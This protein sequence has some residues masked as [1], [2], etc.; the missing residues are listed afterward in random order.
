M[1]KK[2]FIA[3]LILLVIFL[4]IQAIRPQ[5][6][7]PPATAEIVVP[8]NVKSILVKSCYDCHSNQT[9]LR[10]YDEVNPAYWQVV[11]D[12]REGR[13]VLNFSEWQKMPK[14]DQQAKLWEALNQV[15]AGA[16]P[17]PSYTAVHSSA[18]LSEEDINVLKQFLLSK[19]KPLNYNASTDS[20]AS[21][22]FTKWGADSLKIKSVPVALNGIAFIPEYKNW[23]VVSASERFDNGTMRLILGNPIAIKAIREHKIS[24]WPQGATFAKVAFAQNK[25]KDGIVSSG[26]FKQVEFMIKDADKYAS[27]KGWGFARFKTTKMVPYGKTAMFAT[28]CINCHRPEEKTDF[29]FTQPIKLNQ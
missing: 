16:M 10:W 5:L 3:V 1:K 13:K 28:E 6:T 26:E 20:A 24:P 7:N 4:C 14:P 8:D 21:A 11:K 27:T 9:N 17:L 23:Q 25:G 15:V 22:Q 12:V 19:V 29:V 2:Y 18:K